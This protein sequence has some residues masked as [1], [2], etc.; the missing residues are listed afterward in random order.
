M[1]MLFNVKTCEC[2]LG[3]EEVLLI[4]FSTL[5]ESLY[6]KT[7]HFHSL[8]QDYTVQLVNVF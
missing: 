8:P 7:V 1:Q 3:C 6:T 5:K 4:G 2:A